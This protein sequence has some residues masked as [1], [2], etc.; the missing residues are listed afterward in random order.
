[1]GGRKGGCA[2]VRRPIATTNGNKHRER[3]G[4]AEGQQRLRLRRRHREHPRA[5]ISQGSPTRNC[6]IARRSGHPLHPYGRRVSL[7]S[8]QTGHSHTAS[9]TARGKTAATD[10]LRGI[11]TAEREIPG[12]P[13]QPSAKNS[14]VTNVRG[15]PRGSGV[16]W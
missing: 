16:G 10:G 5:A 15:P 11:D 6:P 7:V 2:R 1:M 13:L 9:P 12:A 8:V 3:R 14:K 4:R